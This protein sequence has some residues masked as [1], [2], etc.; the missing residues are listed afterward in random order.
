M[1][2]RA[3]AQ[4]RKWT[5]LFVVLLSM[6]SCGS[7]R[8]GALSTSSLKGVKATNPIALSKQRPAYLP[9]NSPRQDSTAQTIESQLSPFGP[10]GTLLVGPVSSS[11]NYGILCETENGPL[12]ATLYFAAQN[13][14]ITAHFGESADG[15][16]VAVETDNQPSILDVTTGASASLASWNFRK[17]PTQASESNR[18]LQFHPSEPRVAFITMTPEGERVVVL[19][20]DNNAIQT[21]TPQSQHI[22]AIQWDPSGEALYVREADT[23]PPAPKTISQKYAQ[24]TLCL[25]PEPRFLASPTRQRKTRLSVAFPATGTVAVQPDQVLQTTGGALLLTETHRVA[26]KHDATLRDISPKDCEAYLLGRHAATQSLLIGCSDKG[27]MRLAIAS[28]A[29]FFPLDIEILS[30]YDLE[31]RVIVE[32]LLPIYSANRSALIDFESRK[33]I[34][35]NERDQLLAQGGAHILIRRDKQLVRRDLATAAETVLVEAATP[36]A[37]IHFA[38]GWVYL[39]PYLLSATPVANEPFMVEG[40]VL[41]VSN[42]GCALVANAPTSPSNLPNGPVRWVCA[43]GGS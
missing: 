14:Q 40:T 34:S 16:F 19:D 31:D 26:F 11:G 4:Y 43:T 23:A 38:R 13:R 20:L 18:T 42:R 35:L 41:A 8:G 33:L 9:Q 12:V 10:R 17:T 6:P 21:L 22:E 3:Q 32:P 2:E 28:A 25:L 15:R 27:R 5:G 7:A 1:L 36:G 29:G 30:A 24:D 37:K 39:A